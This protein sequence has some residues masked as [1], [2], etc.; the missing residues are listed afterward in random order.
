MLSVNSS[1]IIKKY[2]NNKIHDLRGYSASY[3]GK[4]AVIETIDNDKHKIMKLDKNDIE[5]LFSFPSSPLNIEE[6]LNIHLDDFKKNEKKKTH[7]KRRKKTK[8]AK[9]KRK[10]VK[11]K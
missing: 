9:T 6:R 4:N 7:K 1:R 11:K 3:D 2:K 5:S 8:Q 10:R